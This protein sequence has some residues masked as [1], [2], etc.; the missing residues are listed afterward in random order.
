MILTLCL[1]FNCESLLWYTLRD[2][3]G[4]S[5]D[6]LSLCSNS[7][8]LTAKSSSEDSEMDISGITSDKTSR[9]LF[10]NGIL[11]GLFDTGARELGLYFM[12]EDFLLGRS[13]LETARK[14]Q[15]KTKQ[16]VYVLKNK[17]NNT[18]KA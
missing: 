8:L 5:N 13:L 14:K 12:V 10:F 16:R 9:S 7:S 1:R 18:T 15:N 11:R 3:T 2:L 4:V 6:L 17:L